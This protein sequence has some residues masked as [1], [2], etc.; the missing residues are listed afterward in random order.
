MKL[1][2]TLL[3]FGFS[4]AVASA[5]QA[6][7]LFDAY[8]NVCVKSAADAPAA[9]KI[10]DATG[11]MPIPDAILQQLSVKTGIEGAQGRMKSDSA[12]INMVLIGHKKMPLGGT[13][14]DMRFCAVATTGAPAEPLRGE[15]ETWAAVAPLPELAGDGRVGYAFTVK[16]G[17]HAVV[18]KPNDEEARTLLRSG[19]LNMA[20]IQESQAV[21]LLAFAV[22]TM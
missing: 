2:P 3:A 10:A 19:R 7:P 9:L 1:A 20:F 8:L 18:T 11:W 21:N 22:P 6:G 13:A 17:A 12:A 16:A 4:V 5:A 14:L 15:L